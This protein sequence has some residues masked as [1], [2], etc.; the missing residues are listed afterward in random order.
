MRPE[1]DQSI[2]LN[3]LCTLSAYTQ[4]YYTLCVTYTYLIY[5]GLNLVWVVRVWVW[6]FQ[7]SELWMGLGWRGSECGGRGVWIGRGLSCEVSEIGGSKTGWVWIGKGL[8]RGVWIGRVW[9]GKC[10]NREGPELGGL[11]K[12]NY[13]Q[14]QRQQLVSN[15]SWNTCGR[16]WNWHV[17][18]LHFND[19]YQNNFRVFF[20]FFSSSFLIV[21]E[22]NRFKRSTSYL[23]ERIRYEIDL[24]SSLVQL[25][26]V[27]QWII[28]HKCCVPGC[29]SKFVKKNCLSTRKFN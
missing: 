17:S 24:F 19:L 16:G 10:L 11:N 20:L 9:N 3:L 29:K 7:G 2:R 28:A 18:W 27:Q 15:C 13:S 6:T 8:N 26:Q 12:A 1:C 22:N 4:I 21:Q 14:G 25:P 5:W 23:E